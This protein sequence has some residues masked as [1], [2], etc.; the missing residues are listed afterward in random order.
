MS[1][2]FE[3]DQSGLSIAR[4]RYSYYSIHLSVLMACRV[5][6]DTYCGGLHL[7]VVG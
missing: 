7:F 2:F 4:M 5:H 1:A 6:F 3:M